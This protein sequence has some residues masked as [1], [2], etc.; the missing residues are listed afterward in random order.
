M[1]RHSRFGRGVQINLAPLA[2][3]D[4]AFA[5][6]HNGQEPTVTEHSHPDFQPIQAGVCLVSGIRDLHREIEVGLVS[7]GVD[8]DI[9]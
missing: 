1:C 9:L 8:T 4:L 5:R 7:D 2:I 3:V 6:N